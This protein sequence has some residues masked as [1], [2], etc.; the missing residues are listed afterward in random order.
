MTSCSLGEAEDEAARR[1]GRDRHK[2]TLSSSARRFI[3]R[4]QVSWLVAIGVVKV[5]PVLFPPS[6]SAWTSGSREQLTTYSG[7]TAPAWDRLP[8]QR[9]DCLRAFCDR[10]SVVM[11]AAAQYATED[12]SSITRYL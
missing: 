11:K 3:D 4:S 9:A 1:P 5:T 2:V 12:G 8:W 7:G 6:R 10:Y